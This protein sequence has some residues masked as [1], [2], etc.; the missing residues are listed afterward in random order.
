MGFH[1]D[2]PRHVGRG[3]PNYAAVLGGRRVGRSR[4]LDL[5]PRVLADRPVW[6]SGRGANGLAQS[7]FQGGSGNAGQ[8]PWDP[9]S[10]RGSSFLTG[11]RALPGS[12]LAA[13]VGDRPCYGNVGTWYRRQHVGP[14]GFGELPGGGQ[15]GSVVPPHGSAWS[16]AI[17]L[18]LIFS[19]YFYL[20]SITS[21]YSFYLIEKISSVGCNRPRCTCSISSLPPALGNAL[22]RPDRRI[23]WGRKRVIW[24]SILGVAPLLD[25][26][27]RMSICCGPG[28][29]SFIIGLI[30]GVR[31]FLGHPGVRPGTHAGQSRR[32]CR[33]LFFGLRI[34]NGRHRGAAVL[35]RVWPT[36]ATA[37]N[38]VY[39]MCAF[40]PLLGTVAA[41]FAGYETS[42]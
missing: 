10:P 37:S 40:L 4:I 18:T 33:G 27:C 30:F 29:L 14:C 36:L 7:I 3:A 8:R 5:S 6:Q 26:C 17:L 2:R 15:T 42:A 28:I 38:S 11:A 12:P 25:C 1:A 31:R 39:R 21:Y 13:M 16:V 41:F 35:G 20:A 34:R 24:F 22:G 19:K 9:C 23:A 32:G